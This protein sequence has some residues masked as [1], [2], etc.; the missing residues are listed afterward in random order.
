MITIQ[1]P[2]CLAIPLR[3][4]SRR[5]PRTSAAPRIPQIAPEAP[6]LGTTC[7]LMR[8]QATLDTLPTMPVTT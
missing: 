2:I 4:P 3:H 1:K 7:P 5:T 6:T 8:P